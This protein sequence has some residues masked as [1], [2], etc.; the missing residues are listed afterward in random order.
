[1]RTLAAG[2]LA[3]CWLAA[4]THA[5]AQSEA[6]YLSLIAAYSH[7]AVE[8]PVKAL[9]AWPAARVSANVGTTAGRRGVNW[10]AAAMLHTEVAFATSGDRRSSTHLDAAR[11]LVGRI[12]GDDGREFRARW[13]AW[14]V[15]L[16]IAQGNFSRASQ[17]IHQGFSDDSRSGE[18]GLA[19]GMLSELTARGVEPNLQGTWSAPL[20]NGARE[21]ADGLLK[22]A[23]A[24]YERTLAGAPDLLEARLRLG[25]VLFLN[26]SRPHAREEL[27]RVADRATRPELL[28]LAHLF[29]GA[30]DEADQRVDDAFREYNEAYAV[31]PGQSS[32][33]ALMRLELLVGQD[34]RAKPL[35]AALAT[36]AGIAARD[37]G[38]NY[39]DGITSIALF[40]W[41]RHE[42]QSR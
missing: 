11:T 1:M 16:H 22:D 30:V 24:E 19:R 20:G 29:L 26:H 42:A 39:N 5:S 40:E 23:A 15:V 9:A 3:F 18:L 4:G 13:H 6:D 33:L 2:A 41:L 36:G 37:P 31:V 38:Q 25:W 21:R 27:G 34:R 8:A 17:E 10:K 12:P 35:A 28:Y 32:A 14:I 7:G